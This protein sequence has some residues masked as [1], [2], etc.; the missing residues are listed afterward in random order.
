[1]NDWNRFYKDTEL[2]NM[3]LT[4]I[5][6]K[7]I[8]QFFREKTKNGEYK[9]KR[10]SNARIILNGI[11]YY[12]IDEDII[13]HNPV[14]D[15]NFKSFNYKPQENSMDDVFSDSERKNYVMY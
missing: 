13:T 4:H 3:R 1:M 10:I 7:M 5:T 14:E 15:V 6:P 11:M 9:Y 8:T 12:A 2:S